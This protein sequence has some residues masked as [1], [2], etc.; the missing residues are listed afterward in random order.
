MSIYLPKV[1]NIQQ[2]ICH[3]L[4][5]I[6]NEMD[7]KVGQPNNMLT[8][9]EINLYGA[10]DINTAF[11]RFGA[12]NGQFSVPDNNVFFVGCYLPQSNI[13]RLI[14]PM[15]Y[16]C[17]GQLH[18][19]LPPSSGILHVF[20]FL[21]LGYNTTQQGENFAIVSNVHSSSS[22]IGNTSQNLNINYNFDQVM[23]VVPV[24]DYLPDFEAF[25][26]QSALVMGLQN[27]SGAAI[28]PTYLNGTI[29]LSQGYRNR[30]VFDSD[31]Q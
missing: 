20:A 24:S 15:E 31:G 17:S 12:F 19:H 25:N 10:N 5:A 11:L 27:M 9:D 3:D 4:I 14:A 30:P 29:A 2:S 6:T 21:L 22:S 23:T 16:G 28:A 13:Q 7:F 1:G 8:D 18:M 26:D